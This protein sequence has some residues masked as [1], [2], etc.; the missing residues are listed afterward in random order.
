M[1]NFARI[2]FGKAGLQILRRADIV[3]GA[4]RGIDQDINVVEFLHTT[5]SCNS[6]RFVRLRQGYGG[7]AFAGFARLRPRQ[8]A[9]ER[10]RLAK[11]KKIRSG[12]WRI[13]FPNRIS[14]I[15]QTQR[16]FLVNQTRLPFR[17]ATV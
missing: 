11:A 12:V 9:A 15:F 3:M 10:G 8:P 5:V 4:G 7:T 16:L 13:L 6:C 14:G 17:Y 1:R 2:V